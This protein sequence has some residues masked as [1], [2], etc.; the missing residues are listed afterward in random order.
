[1]NIVI[2]YNGK[3]EAGLLDAVRFA[4]QLSRR[5]EKLTIYVRTREP[6]CSTSVRIR[7]NVLLVADNIIF[8]EPDRCQIIECALFIMPNWQD[9]R[10]LIGARLKPQ[11]IRRIVTVV[12]NPP[13][14]LS[15][16]KASVAIAGIVIQVVYYVISDKVVFLSEFVR[17]KWLPTKRSSVVYLPKLPKSIYECHNIVVDDT[18]RSWLIIGRWL[19]YKSLGLMIDGLEYACQIESDLASEKIL[20][21]VMGNGYPDEEIVRLRGVCKKLQLKFEYEKGYVHQEMVSTQIKL[22][23]RVF[24]L[25][26][27]GSQSGLQQQCR[28]LNTPVLVTQVGGL[29]EYVEIS[30]NDVSIPPDYKVVGRTLVAL[31]KKTEIKSI[32]YIKMGSSIYNVL[33]K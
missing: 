19:P 7:A 25:Y 30:E 13:F 17:S 21:R 18:W 2:F 26:N 20:V 27:S 1:M 15:S 29:G 10:R 23:E 24:F 4:Y 9:C 8:G 12:H 22:A 31:A 33:L 5:N 6:T 14:Q 28:E 32:S 3:G 11:N 16:T